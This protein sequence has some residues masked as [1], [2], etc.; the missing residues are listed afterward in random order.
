MRG[1]YLVRVSPLGEG[2]TCMSMLNTT[3]GSRR[4]PAGAWSPEASVLGESSASGVTR[5]REKVFIF[6]GVMNWSASVGCEAQQTRPPS[7]RDQRERGR[8]L[9]RQVECAYRVDAA[10][11]ERRDWVQGDYGTAA[12]CVANLHVAD[13][14][15][16]RA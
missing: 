3:E 2:T 1:A 16:S 11:E 9:G 13:V 5:S 14:L 15:W 7:Q 10:V 8:T 4:R 12:G 6:P